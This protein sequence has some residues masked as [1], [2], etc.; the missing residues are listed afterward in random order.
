MRKNLYLAVSIIGGYIVAVVM[1]VINRFINLGYIFSIMI[2]GLFSSVCLS[3]YLM[4]F[5]NNGLIESSAGKFIFVSIFAVIITTSNLISPF[6]T[7][8]IICPIIGAYFFIFGIDLFVR[9]GWVLHAAVITD[10][11]SDAYY[12]ISKTTA[13][14]SVLVLLIATIGI[15]FQTWQSRTTAYKIYYDLI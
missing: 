1:T 5:A 8:P 2:Q 15:I 14:E 11:Y 10:S 7:N 12:Y 9:S 6:V 13:L 3:F 4:S